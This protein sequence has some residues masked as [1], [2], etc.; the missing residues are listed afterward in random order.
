MK[1][2]KKGYGCCTSAHRS[3]PTGPTGPT[4]NASGA[5][6]ETGATGST[7]D[8][9]ATGPT[10]ETG[11][12]GPTGETGATGASG[13]TGATGDV[14][15][16]GSTGDVG[17]TGPTGETGATGASGPTGPTGETGATGAG[18][19]VGATGATGGVGATGATGP[20]DASAN[21]L[22]SVSRGSFALAPAT[23]TINGFSAAAPSYNDG[24]INIATGVFTAPVTGRYAF[25]VTITYAQTTALTAQ[26]GA[27]VDPAFRLQRTN[28]PTTLI[29]GHVPILNVNIAL[30]L[31]LRVILG[32]GE[33]ALVS[34]VALNAGDTIELQYVA[35]GLTINLNIG[36]GL[37]P[38]IV[39]SCH[40][41][42]G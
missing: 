38:G 28:V 23:T 42:S 10:G 27:G 20:T 6:G 31:T 33:V 2:I 12:T 5:T 37:T 29:A 26:L 32:N 22:F 13:E 11:A 8:V 9:G 18:G 14:G 30:L 24:S 40:R 3:C 25:K 4:G 41:L 36:G 1:R 17:A 7:G 19:S 21:S 16:T 39:Y 35:D 15:A 34:D